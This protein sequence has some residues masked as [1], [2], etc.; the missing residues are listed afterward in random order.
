[1]YNDANNINGFTEIWNTNSFYSSEYVKRGMISTPETKSSFYIYSSNTVSYDFGNAPE[2][3]YKE[4]P[5]TF[6]EDAFLIQS[7]ETIYLDSIQYCSDDDQNGIY[8]TCV[9]DNGNNMPSFYGVS[10]LLNVSTSSGTTTHEFVIENDEYRVLVP[11][12]TEYIGTITAATVVS[13]TSTNPILGITFTDGT[14]YS[15]ITPTPTPT[16]VVG[17]TPISLSTPQN[18]DCVACRLTT[19]SQTRYVSPIDDTPTIGD[20]V[21]SNSNLSTIFDGNNQWYKTTWGLPTQYSIQIDD[22]GEVID[23]T[24]CSSCPTPTPTPTVAATNT[25]T[26]TITSTPTETPAETPTPT[27]TPSGDPYIYYNADLYSCGFEQVGCNESPIV[28]SA[29]FRFS[30]APTQVWFGV[31]GSAYLITTTTSGPIYDFDGET[32]T[33]SINCIAACGG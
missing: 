9:D 29:I 22:N 11:L 2:G 4:I 23:L 5:G 28:N 12:G 31:S 14:F 17:G 21:Y 32:Y 33:S 16:P 30:S 15:C 26:P 7:A 10:G 13:I 6:N 27:P 20:I 3:W 1:M 8:V 19:Y 24:S 18:D 25:P